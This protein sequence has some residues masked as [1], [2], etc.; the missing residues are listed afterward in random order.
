MLRSI[1]DHLDWMVLF[2]VIVL[3]GVIKSV[4]LRST[5]FFISQ[6]NCEKFRNEGLLKRK[7]V[8]IPYSSWRKKLV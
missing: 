1:C 7:V 6:L 5:N 4:R 3:Q 2:T 8:N